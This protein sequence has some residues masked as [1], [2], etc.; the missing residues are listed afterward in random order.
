MKKIGSLGSNDPASAR[1]GSK[2]PRHSSFYSKKGK[3]INEYEL[4]DIFEEIQDKLDE[5]LSSQAETKIKETLETYSLTPSNDA[6]LLKF[7]AF[8]LEMKGAYLDALAL[9]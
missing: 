8:S 4:S 1:M 5:G 6:M 7:L 9:L 2:S 3:M